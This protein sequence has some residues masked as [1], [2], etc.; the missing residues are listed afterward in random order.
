M[1]NHLRQV[2]ASALACVRAVTLSTSGPA[3]VQASLVSCE[4]RDLRLYL[5]L[6][7]TSDHLLNLESAPTVVVTSAEWSAR[8]EAHVVG[9]EALPEQLALISGPEARWYTLVELNP[10]R[11]ER[12]RAG[13]WGPTET[14]D[15]E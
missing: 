12:L 6:P 3:G 14:I 4:A 10:R 9:A 8:G 1:L 13:G 11:F 5:L 15:I 7:Q 2:V